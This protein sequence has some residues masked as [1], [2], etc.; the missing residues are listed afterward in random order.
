MM[1]NRDESRNTVT[2][3]S[4]AGNANALSIFMKDLQISPSFRIVMD[5]P[6]TRS[7]PQMLFSK[8]KSEGKGSTRWHATTDKVDITSMVSL[9]SGSSISKTSTSSNSSNPSGSGKNKKLRRKLKSS[10][11]NKSNN[12]EDEEEPSRA[13]PR[14][15]SFDA[16]SIACQRRNNPLNRSYSDHLTPTK[17]NNTPHAPTL[18]KRRLSRDLDKAPQMVVRKVGAA[19]NVSTANAR[20]PRRRNTSRSPTRHDATNTNSSSSSSRSP[21]RTTKDLLLDQVIVS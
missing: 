3:S 10:V 14:S 5:N 4:T 19:P 6:R 16:S 20:I 21:S 12:F 9:S 11:K 17:H 2:A 8:S 1:D 18:P 13:P 7:S 15:S